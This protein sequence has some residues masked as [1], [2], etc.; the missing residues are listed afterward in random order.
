[1]KKLLVLITLLFFAGLLVQ[2]GCSKKEVSDE[3]ESDTEIVDDDGE[4]EDV[5]LDTKVAKFPASVR[6]DVELTE[7][8]ATLNTAEEVQLLEVFDQEIKGKT[9]SLSRVRLS[10]DSEGYIRSDYLADYAVVIVSDKTP[11]FKR[12]NTTSGVA[13]RLP[14]GTVAMVEEEKG[15]WL[16]ITAGELPD[17]TKVY[18]KWIEKG[19]SNDKALVTEAVIIKNAIG[20]LA[21]SVKGDASIARDSLNKIASS[22]SELSSVAELALDGTSAVEKDDYEYADDLSIGTVSAGGGL[23]VRSDPSVDGE[24]LVLIPSGSRVGVVDKVGEEVEIGGKTNYWYKVNYQ[25]TVGFAF[26]AFIDGI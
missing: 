2:T 1:M 8:V 21:G 17:G 3:N 10:D 9:Y 22:G 25:G 4:V 19:F 5:E 15:G 6:K 12:N 20:V 24:E 11:A 14:V 7:W 23:K 13:A 16:K 26:G 18:G